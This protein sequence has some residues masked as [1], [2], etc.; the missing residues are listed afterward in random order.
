MK[1]FGKRFFE[2]VFSKL[3]GDLNKKIDIHFDIEVYEDSFKVELFYEL[4][5]TWYLQALKH[6]LKK[7]AE[8]PGVF[9]AD[10][11]TFSYATPRLKNTLKKIERDVQRD[12]KAFRIVTYKIK[13]MVFTVKDNVVETKI[14]V[15]GLCVN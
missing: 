10:Q 14:I 3:S 2:F 11:R 9:H 7:D 5:K 12:L 15:E 6:V 13:D 1:V 4:P 8:L